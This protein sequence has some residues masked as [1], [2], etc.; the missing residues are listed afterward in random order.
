[1][2]NVS[3]VLTHDSEFSPHGTGIKSHEGLYDDSMFA[4]NH[5]VSQTC[6][7]EDILHSLFPEGRWARF[8]QL[9]SS[10]PKRAPYLSITP[11]LSQ[12]HSAPCSHP[13]ERAWQDGVGRGEAGMILPWFSQCLVPRRTSSLNVALER[14]TI[15][16]FWYSKL[17]IKQIIHLSCCFLFY[18]HTHTPLPK[19]FTMWPFWFFRTDPPIKA[20][21]GMC[22]FH[23]MF[24][25]RAK[26]HFQPKQVYEVGSLSLRD[27]STMNQG[28]AEF[29]VQVNINPL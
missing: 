22:V 23:E 15:H 24:P 1:M 7:L 12:R 2:W 11:T 25:G 27:G 29:L 14:Y 20:L 26:M 4:L 18:T 8:L 13:G 5:I 28:Q 21:W 19:P 9:H 17:N 6:P 10:V 3:I 16:F